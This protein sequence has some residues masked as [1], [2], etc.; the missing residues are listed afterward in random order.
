MGKELHPKDKEV[1]NALCINK[2]TSHRV[3]PGILHVSATACV[4]AS[5]G[6]K[7]RAMTPMGVSRRGK[8]MDVEI[9]LRKDLKEIRSGNSLGVT[10]KRGNRDLLIEE[11]FEDLCCKGQ[12]AA[13]GTKQKHVGRGVVV[14]GGR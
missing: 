8:E 6:R 4:D 1:A 9:E 7:A 3:A 13:R 5:E 12:D 14:G 11:G 10:L 2:R